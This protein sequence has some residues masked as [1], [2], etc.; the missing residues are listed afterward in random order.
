M[1]AWRIGLLFIL[2]ILVVY[3]QPQPEEDYCR[4][5]K[6]TLHS[7]EL[8]YKFH[9]PGR[10]VAA[11]QKLWSTACI[12]LPVA[13]SLSRYLN[14]KSW[15]ISPSAGDGHCLLYSVCASMGGQA[16][17]QHIDY[18]ELKSLVF[19]ETIT[20]VESYASFLIPSSSRGVIKG[21]QNYLLRKHYNHAFG[22]II[23]LIVSNA[24]NVDIGI[25]NELQ[26]STFQEISVKSTKDG[27]RNGN[28]YI[29]RKGDH[30]NGITLQPWAIPV[31]PV[32]GHRHPVEPTKPT[33]KQYTSGSLK[34]MRKNYPI[35]R[36]TRKSLFKLNLW[37]PS[38]K[39]KTKPEQ[40]V[41]GDTIP[42]RITGNKTRTVRCSTQN[43]VVLQNLQRVPLSTIHRH[44]AS[45][46]FCHLNAQSIRQKSVAIRN[47]ILD[48]DIDLL[49]ITESW[50][51]SYELALL[52]ELCPDGYLYEHSARDD[53]TGGGIV[54]VY[55]GSVSLSVVKKDIIR[56]C[57][58]MDI[59]VSHDKQSFQLI[60]IYRP[61]VDAKKKKKPVAEFFEDLLDLTD[62]YV[63]SEKELL[64]VGD[65]N[66]HVDDK[67]S[68]EGVQFLDLLSSINLVQ[69]VEEPT[70]R[71]GHTLD[72]LIS[73]DPEFVQNVIVDWAISDHFSVLC[74][75]PLGKPPPERKF[76]KFRKYHDIDMTSF[77]NEL[78]DKLTASNYSD[79]LKSAVSVYDNVLKELLDKYAPLQ[80]RFIT[81]R[82]RKRQM[83]HEVKAEKHSTRQMERKWRL[84]RAVCDRE[85]YTQQKIKYHRLLQ[86][87]ETEFNSRLVMKNSDNP[88][89][90]FNVMNKLL[91]RKQCNPLPP[92]DSDEQLANDFGE[93]FVKKIEK[94]H[95]ELA[96]QRLDNTVSAGSDS[97][98]YAN[99]LSEFSPVTTDDV[100]CI[101]HKSSLKS[102][103]LD[104]LPSWM[105]R[106][107]ED[108][109]IPVIRSIINLSFT[110]STVP[111]E[112]KL[113]I[114]GPRIK[115]L[116]LA[117]IL[118]SYRPV[119]N[120]QF[121]SKLIERSVVIQIVGHM[122][123]N[124]L[125]EKLQS[126]YLEG[127]S[128]ETALVRV[129]NDI[130]TAMDK[131]LVTAVLFL[132]LSA[133][134]DTV[135]HHILLQRLENRC[136]ITGSALSWIESYLSQRKQV[137]KVNDSKSKVYDLHCGVPQGSVL[138]PILFIIYIL[139][140]GDIVRKHN[141]SFHMFADDNQTYLSFKAS[142]MDQSLSRINACVRDIQDWLRENNLKCNDTKTDLLICGT[143]QQLVKL[144]SPS[145]DMGSCTIPPSQQVRNLGV[146]F[147]D[148]MSLKSH[149]GAVSKASY[150]Q[151]FNINRKRSSLTQEA[152]R[153]CIHAF[154]TSKIDNCNALLYGLPKCHSTDI[155]QRVQNAAARTLLGIKKSSRKHMSPVLRDIHWLPVRRRIEFK[156]LLVT[157]K[158]L[159]GVGP[160][161]IRELL[162]PY[163]SAD[164]LRSAKDG[165]RLKEP[166]RK[167]K[168]GGLR[169]YSNVAP[170][171]WNRLP[172]SLRS[173]KSVASFKSG[174]KTYFFDI[175]RPKK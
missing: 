158:A 30:F 153:T 111:E 104:P 63:L 79:S 82:H 38:W 90:L 137:V 112:Y 14:T 4:R 75:L 169:A 103:E 23:P 83:T 124:Q 102:C 94:I 105:V 3:K 72:I 108:E 5:S 96:S 44:H 33:I 45:F 88:K 36:K 26:N 89:S 170:T 43:S 157:Y 20:N 13:M 162:V 98:L 85:D 110:E 173:A 17:Q 141:L 51:F 165:H 92:H 27:E 127:R 101:L 93:F 19:I 147:D 22:D 71:N 99:T 152:T 126:A 109:L 117:L 28:L 34:E 131:Q 145:I 154:V 120:L 81:L 47:Y 167:L 142:D 151:L 65:L 41:C 84:T 42:V 68:S 12:A 140:L 149:V 144:N 50:H 129:Q 32:I 24:L 97:P 107:S 150:F 37:D 1:Y 164:C 77:R 133:A 16:L 54:I 69:H 134:F 128:V 59:V 40:T 146:I 61:E 15:I 49:V 7:P 58:Y 106:E 57:E 172:L 53:R 113:A 171:L 8:D 80:E 18:S 31:T 91:G 100:K 119:S 66:L 67:T 46:K 78:R 64:I 156:I 148:N 138:G 136:G 9:A 29:H 70:H 10:I 87:C 39:T 2:C 60:A 6:L 122:K 168:T 52:K 123:G 56:S 130:L 35:N 76:V 166:I 11:K 161:Y 135:S 132:D 174:L 74:N 175:D 118:N 48:N 155:L 114:L 116:G 160:E 121:V 95:S 115:K 73:R 62:D 86:K 159:H 139:P 125:F 21:L 143:R 25:L 163:K 55:R